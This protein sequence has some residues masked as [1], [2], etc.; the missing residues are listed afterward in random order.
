[1]ESH[2]QTNKEWRRRRIKMRRKVNED[3]VQNNVNA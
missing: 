2:K 3:K 1:M